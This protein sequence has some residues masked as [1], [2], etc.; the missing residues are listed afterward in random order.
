MALTFLV[1]AAVIAEDLRFEAPA[2]PKLSIHQFNSKYI[3]QISVKL[4]LLCSYPVQGIFINFT[5]RNL[6]S[7]IACKDVAGHCTYWKSK[8]YCNGRYATF[9]KKKCRKTCDKCKYVTFLIYSFFI[10]NILYIFYS[11]LGKCIDLLPGTCLHIKNV[12]TC[13][14]RCVSELCKDTCNNCKKGTYF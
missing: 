13:K 2:K 8:G 4:I 5:K 1:I 9:M 14:N 7:Q 3:N 12:L 10:N 6:I 11:T